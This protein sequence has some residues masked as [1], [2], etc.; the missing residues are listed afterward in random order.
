MGNKKY[1]A[2]LRDKRASLLAAQANLINGSGNISDRARFNELTEKINDVDTRIV[3][4]KQSFEGMPGNRKVGKGKRAVH[5]NERELRPNQSFRDY[6]EARGCYDGL[7]A[8]SFN[9]DRY[10]TAKMSQRGI[11][12]GQTGSK[13]YTDVPELRY[14]ARAVSGM[15]ED[16]TSG[17]GAGGSV[18]PQIWAHNVIDIIRAKTFGNRVNVTTIPM[19]S[20]I[21]N[22]P[23]LQNELAPVY[24]ASQAGVGLDVGE[25][26]GTIQ[27]NCQGA[28]ADIV[29]ADKSLIEDAVNS[30]G[31][32]GLIQHSVA[33]KYARLLDQVSL[34]GQTG[35]PGA[36]GLINESSLQT[37]NVSGAPTTYVPVSQAAA[38]IRAWECACGRRHVA[39]AP[40]EAAGAPGT[41][42]YGLNF[43]A[44]CV[45]LLVMHHVP[46]ERCADILESMSGTRPS[47]GW[48][49]TL[50][51]RA[52]RAVAA[53]NTAIRALIILARVI[54]GD[55]TPVRVGP[56]PKTAKRYLL[57]ACTN[58]LTCYFLGDRDLASFKGFIYSDLH[59]AVVVHDRY[60]NYDSFDGISHQLCCQHY[61]DTAVMPISR[62]RC[63]QA[64]VRGAG[65]SA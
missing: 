5:G 13:R 31:I 56:G 35:H 18:V 2:E 14:E 34:Y 61:P 20:E 39:V 17:A 40:P 11:D 27:L 29:N 12:I 37:F 16:L 52:A 60:Q 51:G 48:V 41:V 8:H 21:M 59:G 38:K 23:T 32:N 46:V 10:W 28:F 15:S 50:L 33:M 49:H 26:L 64:G 53:A 57:V 4:A 6:A 3:S 7:D 45:F 1:I 43:Q 47:D 54:C 36:P 63:W 25:Q 42:T 55:E 58:M 19:T 22:L 9:W 62:W 44:W 24:V 30:G 65:I